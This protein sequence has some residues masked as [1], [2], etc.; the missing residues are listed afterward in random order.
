MEEQEA[1]R[2]YSGAF[3]GLDEDNRTEMFI[4]QYGMKHVRG[5][6]YC[7]P[8]TEFSAEDRCQVINWSCHQ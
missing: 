2:V 8:D 4:I 3:S 5:G 6:I 7:T 1:Y